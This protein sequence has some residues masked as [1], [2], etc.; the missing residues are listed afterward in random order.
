MYPHANMSADSAPPR[1]SIV[2]P[3][4]S[5]GPLSLK[6]TP[7]TPDPVLRD[8]GLNFQRALNSAQ[9]S[10]RGITPAATDIGIATE[11]F[12][13]RAFPAQALQENVAAHYEIYD[14]TVTN[15]FANGLQKD[16]DAGTY[17]SAISKRNDLEKLK[18][19]YPIFNSE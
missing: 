7:V 17:R 8:F 10:N 16:S 11:N 5:F 2:S 4:T 19:R 1:S 14:H 15:L 12:K 13:S 6:S 3:G 18:A 9:K